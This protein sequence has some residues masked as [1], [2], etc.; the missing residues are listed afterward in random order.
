[1]AHVPSLLPGAPVLD[2]YAY[3]RFL[4]RSRLA[5]EYLRR[6]SDYRRDWRIAAPG[7]PFYIRMS[8][9]TV[10]LRARRRFLRAEAWGLCTFRRSGRKRARGGGLLAGR[11]L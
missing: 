6:N 8:D 3:I 11:G 5:W 9:D 10:L 4:T 2:D 1:M 7:Q